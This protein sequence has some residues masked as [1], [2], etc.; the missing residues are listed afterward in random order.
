[1]KCPNCDLVNPETALRCDCGYDFQ[2]GQ[3]K[4]SYLI[5]QPNKGGRLTS[6]IPSSVVRFILAHRLHILILVLVLYLVGYLRLPLAAIRNLSD[7]EIISSTPVTFSEKTEVSMAQR[8]YLKRSLRESP[9][10]TTPRIFVRVEWNMFLLARVNTSYYVNEKGAEY[11]DSVYLCVFGAW[12][13]IFTYD[14]SFS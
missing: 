14:H 5:K 1:M 7:Y 11:N 6:L 13:P 4:G 2:S 10:P 3:I 9:V 12:A 8:W